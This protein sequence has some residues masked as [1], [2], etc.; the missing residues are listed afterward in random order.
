MNTAFLKTFT[1]LVVTPNVR[2][3]AAQEYTTP[4]T[5]SMRI[6]S[7]ESELNVKLFD[8]E[9]GTLK[10]TDHGKRLY[11]YAESVLKAV[12]DLILSAAVRR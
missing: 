1:H 10:L 12:D 6:K 7:L 9:K 11:S 4:S 3:V 8:R 5:I 2:K